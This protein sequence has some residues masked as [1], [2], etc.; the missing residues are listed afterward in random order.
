V[1]GKEAAVPQSDGV[2]HGFCSAR[3]SRYDSSLRGEVS[4]SRCLQDA[5][6]RE[7]T[8]SIQTSVRKT[9]V[10]SSGGSATFGFHPGDRLR[11]IRDELRGTTQPVTT[12]E[13]AERIMRVK[14]LPRLM[15]TA[16]TRFRRRSSAHSTERR[17]L[18][19]SRPWVSS[20]GGPLARK[21]R[22]RS[23]AAAYPAGGKTI[24]PCLRVL[25]GRPPV[26]TVN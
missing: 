14:A 4:P 15:I 9:S 18:C 7:G 1:I 13:L 21:R 16:V 10:Q 8:G 12:R 11:L 24:L 5:D 23:P 20:V 22:S 25:C 6:R 2:P 3:A 19:G 26:S 17:P